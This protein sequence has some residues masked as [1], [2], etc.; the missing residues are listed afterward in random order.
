MSCDA[1]DGREA[2]VRDACLPFPVD[3][4]VRLRERVR[5][6]QKFG[7]GESRTPFRSLWTMQRSCMYFN[8]F[9]T[10]AN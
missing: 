4:D 5:G 8:P 2:E 9:A 7:S 3:Q 6:V 1:G 10:P